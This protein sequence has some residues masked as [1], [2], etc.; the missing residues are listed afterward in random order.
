[1]LKK[2]SNWEARKL[3]KQK[4]DNLVRLHRFPPISSGSHV[5]LLFLKFLNIG[6]TNF[7]ELLNEDFQPI[8]CAK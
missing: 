6:I 5:K 7:Q 4:C 8:K 1:M 3:E 2:P